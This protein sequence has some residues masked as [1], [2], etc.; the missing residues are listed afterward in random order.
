MDNQSK[1]MH[2]WHGRKGKKADLVGV[3]TEEPPCDEVFLDDVHAPHTNEA[4]TTV[5][6]PALASNKGNG[7]T[8]SQSQY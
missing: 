4:Y 2:G 5:C 1:G 3:H 7:L 6:L 8:L